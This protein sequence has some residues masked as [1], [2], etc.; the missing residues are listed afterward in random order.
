MGAAILLLALVFLFATVYVAR[1]T[2]GHVALDPVPFDRLN[3]ISVVGAALIVFGAMM[4]LVG[5][6]GVYGVR[7]P[8]SMRDDA[9][10]KSSQRFGALVSVVSGAAIVVGNL[11]IGDLIGGLAFM[12]AVLALCGVSCGLHSYISSRKANRLDES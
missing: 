9:S 7:T 1:V 12:L 10:W 4:P 2:L 5:K 11:Y 8:W 6:N 3:L